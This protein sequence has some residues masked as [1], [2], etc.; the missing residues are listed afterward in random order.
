[1]NTDYI[2]SFY[3]SVKS[4]G[5]DDNILNILRNNV[6]LSNIRTAMETKKLCKCLKGG[7]H[8]PCVMVLDGEIGQVRLY[9]SIV[10][11]LDV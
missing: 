10:S 3:F 8:V 5:M 11:C 4:A 9:V 7:K 1:M 2:I 6:N